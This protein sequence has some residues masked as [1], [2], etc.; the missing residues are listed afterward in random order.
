MSATARTATSGSPRI[1]A[2]RLRKEFVDI[3]RQAEVVALSSIDLDIGEDEFLT[4][5]G[6]SGCGKSTLLNIIAGFEQATDGEVRLDGQI[7]R[8]PGPDRGVVFQEYA[9]FPWLNVAQ[10]IE[11]GLRERG[12]PKAER[13]DR[14]TR[15]ISTVGLDGFEDRFPQELSGGMRQ[16]VALARVLV[17]DPKIL[18]MDEPFAALDAQTRTIMQTELLRVWSAE[19]R[20]ALFVTHNIEEAVLLGDR[21]VVMTARPGRI[22]EIVNVNLP[23]PR[24][25]TSA[26]FNEIRRYVASLLEGEVQT[27]FA[28]MQAGKN[29]ES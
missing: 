2:R 16:R 7:I 21:L 19:R 4:I 8:N 11:F 1:V 20:T 13:K 6:P 9:L 27:A 24:D 18:L 12:V 22:K 26:E 5:L 17:N 28:S 10:N 25:V 15:Q 14:V 3:S 23:R 29:A